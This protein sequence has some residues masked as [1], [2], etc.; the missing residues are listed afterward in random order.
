M[1]MPRDQESAR[2]GHGMK[3]ART[4]GANFQAHS[5]QATYLTA[6]FVYPPLYP[7][8]PKEATGE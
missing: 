6:L 3:P 8:W 2:S 5:H 1:V 4:S 7:N